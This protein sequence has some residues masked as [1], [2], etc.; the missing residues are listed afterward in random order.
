MFLD[1]NNLYGWIMLQNLPV[2]NFKWIEEDNLSKFDEKFIKNYDVDSDIGY[3]LEVEV[4]YPK[5][6]HKLHSHLPFLPERKKINKCSKLVNTL[7]YKKKL[8]YPH[9]SFKASTRSWIKTN[10][11]T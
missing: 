7:H 10:K 5:S 1:A 9:K 11:G 4:H 3:L 2:G 8:C 6:F